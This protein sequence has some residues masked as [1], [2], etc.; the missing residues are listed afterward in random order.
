MLLRL[1]LR[2]LLQFSKIFVVDFTFSFAAFLLCH[3]NRINYR[4]CTKFSKKKLN[5]VKCGY[6]VS[7]KK[8][9][10][11]FRITRSVAIPSPNHTHFPSRSLSFFRTSISFD[12]KHDCQQCEIQEKSS[13]SVFENKNTYKHKCAS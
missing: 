1:L 2:H 11:K 4:I 9:K 6:A 10:Q 8:R 7:V 5:A 12:Y 3:L 13:R